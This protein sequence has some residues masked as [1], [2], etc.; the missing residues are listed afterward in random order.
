MR[1]PD[2][3][4]ISLHRLG[5]LIRGMYDILATGAPI[6]K[7][8]MCQPARL[9]SVLQYPDFRLRTVLMSVRSSPRPIHV[10]AQLRVVHAAQ[11]SRRA[12]RRPAQSEHQRYPCS[13]CGKERRRK[14]FTQPKANPFDVADDWSLACDLRGE[15]RYPRL[16]SRSGLRPDLVAISLRSKRVCS[17]S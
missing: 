8:W 2:L 9:R 10:A 4:T 13:S 17:S 14:K 16:I 5:F 11:C 7:M 3:Q 12:S 15:G 6:S 1:W